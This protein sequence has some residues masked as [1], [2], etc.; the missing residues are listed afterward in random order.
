MCD[1]KT[2]DDKDNCYFG[3]AQDTF[4]TNVKDA[5]D[6]CNKINSITSKENCL[7]LFV[8]TPELVKNNQD[9]ALYACSLYGLK[10]RCYNDVARA[11]SAVD[12]KKA[13]QIC[14]KLDD[15]IQISDC[16]GSAWFSFNSIVIENFD[17][18]IN[19]CKVLTLKKDDCLNRIVGVFM[20]VD[21]T[22]AGEACKL[23]SASTS[24]NCLESV[25]R[26]M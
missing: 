5:I 26:R 18:T 11:I 12:Q 25:N 1:A 16:Y 9:L 2:G 23:L 4:R 20:D 3:I 14:Q 13:A 8:N 17:F 15:D 10:S 24:K 6:F 19:L 7:G 21:R 22:K